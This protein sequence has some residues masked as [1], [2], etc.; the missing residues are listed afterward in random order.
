[1]VSHV[2]TYYILHA[3]EY[4]IC[5]A[6][7]IARQMKGEEMKNFALLSMVLA[8]FALSAC[9]TLEGRGTKE[10]VGG[11][12]GAVAGGIIGSQIGSGSGRL[13]ATGA[14]V[15]LGGLL[16]SEIGASLDNAD[17]AAAAQAQRR[18]YDAPI[19]ETVSWNN[20]DSGNYGTYTPTREGQSSYGRYCREYEQ[21]I[22]V[23]GRQETAVGQACQNPDGTWEIMS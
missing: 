12:G 15:L 20:P 7:R 22:Y 6:N 9:Q 11:V 21:M 1:M 18:A 23:D 16:G 5:C 2:E 3:N 10:T 17:R 13:W 8:V 19:G 4:D 14:G